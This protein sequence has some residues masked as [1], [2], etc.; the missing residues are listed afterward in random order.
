MGINGLSPAQLTDPEDIVDLAERLRD[1]GVSE[2]TIGGL[3][4]K[5]RD[6]APFKAEP[7]TLSR[8][9]D[10]VPVKAPKP[11][12]MTTRD[13]YRAALGG[14]LVGFSGEDLP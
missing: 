8:D 6:D 2:F 9:P 13:M 5:F 3:H 12:T 10:Y 11:A 1:L 4:V 14:K 7:V